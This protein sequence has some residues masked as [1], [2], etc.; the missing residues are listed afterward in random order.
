LCIDVGELAASLCLEPAGVPPGRPAAL[1]ACTDRGLE[2]VVVSDQLDPEECALQQSSVPEAWDVA[3]FATV[4]AAV[5][6]PAGA[7]VHD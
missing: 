6:L 7:V 2:L 5:A 1:L 4:P 3:A